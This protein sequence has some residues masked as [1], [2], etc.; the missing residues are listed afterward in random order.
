[1]SQPVDNKT[2]DAL[3]RIH[4]REVEIQVLVEVF[5]PRPRVDHV[6]AFFD[7]LHLRLL[8]VELV[9]DLTDQFFEH[10]LDRDDPG[11][12]PVLIEDDRHVL[13]L[14]LKFL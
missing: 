7:P 13:L 2:A 6:D 10:I 12:R 14:Y 5:H 1:M 11:K 3:V 4:H 9:H 8:L